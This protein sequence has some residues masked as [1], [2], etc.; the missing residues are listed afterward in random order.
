MPLVTRG[1]NSLSTRYL[2]RACT[3]THTFLS[4]LL[5]GQSHQTQ[6][7]ELSSFQPH[8]CKCPSLSSQCFLFLKQKNSSSFLLFI[9]E[10]LLIKPCYVTFNQLY[11]LT[12]NCL[13]RTLESYFTFY[14]YVALTALAIQNRLL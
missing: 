7:P 3:Y 12:Y 11:L 2:E 1:I 4:L 9:L 6:A 8:P 13:F 14:S 5:S 10:V